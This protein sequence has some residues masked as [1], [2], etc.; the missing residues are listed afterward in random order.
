MEKENGVFAGMFF[1]VYKS[2]LLGTWPGIPKFVSAPLGCI[3]ANMGVP[4][5]TFPIR[6]AMA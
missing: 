4:K 5:E 1:S 6:S 3:T 2:C